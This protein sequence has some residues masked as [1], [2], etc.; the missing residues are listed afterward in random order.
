[1]GLGLVICKNLVE[2]MGGEIGFSS[3]QGKGS[4]FYFNIP[5]ET[6]SLYKPLVTDEEVN[7][8]LLDE[9]KYSR[10]AIRN[11]LV[12]MGINTFAVENMD[13]LLKV[14]NNRN[15]DI[16]QDVVMLSLP[17]GYQVTDFG[18]DYLDIVRSHFDGRIIVL[19]AGDYS[20][21]HDI[22]QLDS[23]ISIIGKPLRSHSLQNI[24]ILGKSAGQAENKIELRSGKHLN[25]SIHNILVVEDNELNQRYIMDLLSDYAVNVVCVDNGIKAVDACKNTYFDM[26]FMD[27]HMPELDGIDAIRQIRALPGEVANT[28]V[29]AITADI[30]VNDN[31]K[32]TE[33]G[34]TDLMLKPM[35]EDRLDELINTYINLSASDNKTT[36]VTKHGVVSNMPEDMVEKLFESLYKDYTE[37]AQTL[38]D[39]NFTR[40][41][42]LAHEVLGLVSYF[43]VGSLADDIRHLQDAIKESDFDNASNLLNACIEQTRKVERD[44]RAS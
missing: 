38:I 33:E 12:H 13:R 32:L 17:A 37:L 2:L 34:F 41:H 4:E 6:V 23:Q 24:L 44:W 26:I 7:A 29:I 27:L 39:E 35:D 8:F 18:E 10:R 14:L 20:D 1:T 21:A 16:K 31:D 3:E 42:E 5:M 19:L 36:A 15:A 9:H 40:M 43:K 25:R 22:S 30:F 11:T 28:P